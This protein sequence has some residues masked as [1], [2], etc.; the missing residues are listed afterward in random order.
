MC[1]THAR[2]E[3]WL[4]GCLDSCCEVQTPTAHDFVTERRE[5]EFET[6]GEKGKL[7]TDSHFRIHSAPPSPNNH[8][9]P[10]FLILPKDFL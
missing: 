9:G 8:K 1:V 5:R 3:R 2:L 6:K 10:I 7:Q 4:M